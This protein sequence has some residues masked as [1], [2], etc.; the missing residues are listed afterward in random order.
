M[1]DRKSLLDGDTQGLLKLSQT[2]TEESRTLLDRISLRLSDIDSASA[3]SEELLNA[4]A[5]LIAEREH[6]DAL[7]AEIKERL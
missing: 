2:L 4:Q 7:I 5:R 1:D 3:R 6:I